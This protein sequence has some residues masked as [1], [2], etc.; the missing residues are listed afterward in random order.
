MSIT[1]KNSIVIKGQCYLDGKEISTEEAINRI[2]EMGREEGYGIRYL[3]H[4]LNEGREQ[5]KIEY[6]ARLIR[7][8]EGMKIL[9]STGEYACYTIGEIEAHNQLIIDILK[10]LSKE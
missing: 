8:I 1:T 2:L 3:E 6:K 9:K 5:G 7:V 4:L 10:E